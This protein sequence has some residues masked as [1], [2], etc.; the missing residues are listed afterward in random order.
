MFSPQ[1]PSPSL[2]HLYTQSH[3]FLKGA[4]YKTG[5]PRDSNPD[6]VLKRHMLY[7]LSS[8]PNIFQLLTS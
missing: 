4:N 2:Q 8:R 7:H 1:Q 3:K 5:E 6:P